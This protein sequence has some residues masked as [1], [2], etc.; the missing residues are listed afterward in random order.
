MKHH[1]SY[2]ITRLAILGFLTLGFAACGSA[3]IGES[4]DVPGSTDGC[5]ENA[6]CTNEDG[7]SACRLLCDESADCP[8]QHKCNGITGTDRK[9]CQPDKP[10][11]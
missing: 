1:P 6:I 5:V 2:P 10:V 7:R 3:D 8:A 11:K 9:S 4:C